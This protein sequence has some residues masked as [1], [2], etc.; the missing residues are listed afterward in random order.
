MQVQ[1]MK[2]EIYMRKI[3]IYINKEYVCTTTQAKTCKQAIKNFKENPLVE[4]LMG[5]QYIYIDNK[6]KIT[7]HFVK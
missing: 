6:D 4:T 7:A 3:D 1:N 5:K 2:G